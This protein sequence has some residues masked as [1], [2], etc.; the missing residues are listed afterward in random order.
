MLGRKTLFHFCRRCINHHDVITEYYRPLVS[1]LSLF[2]KTHLSSI[3]SNRIS[4]ETELIGPPVSVV[5][6]HQT[7]QPKVT[8]LLLSLPKRTPGLASLHSSPRPCRRAVIVRSL[9]RP[10]LLAAR[11]PPAVATRPSGD[12]PRAA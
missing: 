12:S 7:G 3:S 8:G 9:C 4:R 10:C 2:Q 11:L 5:N 6:M 1:R